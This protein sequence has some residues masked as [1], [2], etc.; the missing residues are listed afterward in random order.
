MKAL[1]WAA[2]AAFGVSFAFASS[3]T[4]VPLNPGMMSVAPETASSVVTVDQKWGGKRHGKWKW[5]LRHHR[6]HS[7]GHNKRW[8]HKHHRNN[9]FGFAFGFGLPLIGF[10]NDGPQCI[11]RW[12]RHYSGRLHCHG[13]LIY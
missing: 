11:G 9:D 10:Y 2:L 8:R 4:A 12:H 1:A 13:R 6:H 7:W 3:A 5:K